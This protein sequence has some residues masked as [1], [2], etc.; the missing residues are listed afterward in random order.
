MGPVMSRPGPLRVA[1]NMALDNRDN[2]HDAD[3]LLSV[4]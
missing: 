2:R 3:R 4:L 1:L